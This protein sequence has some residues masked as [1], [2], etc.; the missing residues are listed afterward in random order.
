MKLQGR[1]VPIAHVTNALRDEMFVL[2]ETY[3]ENMDRSVFEA[4]LAEKQW[5][6]QVVD[7]ITGAICGFSTQMLLDL[8]VEGRPVR[9]LFS[10]DTIVLHEY[11]GQ[12][13]LAQVWGRFALSLINDNPSAELYWF[14]ITKGY[15][16][17]RFLPVF[18]HKFYPRYDAPTPAWATAVI[19]AVGPFKYGA[20]YAADLGIVRAHQCGCRLRS[21]IAEITLPRLQDPHVRF[22]TER[23][24]GHAR[25]DELC[26][27]APLTREN[28]TLAAYRVIG[29]PLEVTPVPL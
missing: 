7:P 24:P 12:N 6:I 26:C 9:A 17:Y 14:L 15:K 27:L 13:P 25:G 10:G 21:G 18:F 29:T 2:M 28:F 8:A 5:V 19:S 16:T 4:D 11:W 23:N 3:Y 22:F 1:L 20:A